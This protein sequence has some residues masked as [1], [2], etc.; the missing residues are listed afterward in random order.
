MK[1]NYSQ[2]EKKMQMQLEL[3]VWAQNDNKSMH[4]GANL[5]TMINR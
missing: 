4:L 3:S 2:T 1:A 5:T